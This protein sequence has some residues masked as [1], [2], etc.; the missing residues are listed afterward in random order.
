MPQA[1]TPGFIRHQ[2]FRA[3]AA[4]IVAPA[5]PGRP[6]QHKRFRPG[7]R[8]DPA[9]A[10]ATAGTAR[11]DRQEAH[12]RVAVVIAAAVRR[13]NALT[14]YSHYTPYRSFI[15]ASL[16]AT[17]FA[18]STTTLACFQVASSCI[19]P[20][21]MTAPE[22]SG[23]AA[24]IFSANFTSLTSGEKTRLAIAT[25]LGCSVQA[26]AQPIRKALRNCASQAAGSEKSPNGP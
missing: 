2:R 6:C 23:I 21:I 8:S 14:A 1:G 3:A 18:R 22:P 12:V 4:P 5:S 7:N 20:S 13:D 17:I 19:L 26:P 25:W 10:Q 11:G 24:R 15:S 9:G 16:P